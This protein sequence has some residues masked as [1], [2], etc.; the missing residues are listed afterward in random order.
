M[1][2]DVKALMAEFVG[3]FALVFIGALSVAVAGQVFAEGAGVLGVLIAA[4]AHGL[5][6]LGFAFA[7]G[8]LSG[9]HFN[10]AVTAG[11]LAGGKVDIARAISYWVVQFIAAIVAAF[12]M[13]AV[14]PAEWGISRFGQT[15]GVITSS[16]LV[17]AVL[18][19]AILTFL[20]VTVI[21]QTAAHGKAGQFAPIA[22]G[23]T[24]TFCILGGGVF[25]GASLNPAR[26]LGPAL[27]AGDLSYVPGY[28]IGIFAGGVLAG[29]FNAYVLTPKN[30]DE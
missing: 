14:V 7:V 11:L 29:V 22:I 27:A 15:V 2:L 19:E 21:F 16:N 24:L 9:G 12:A 25:S 17:G 18:L 28:L 20:F 23:L 26:T 8:H 3:T 10:P 5:V 4:F 6:V 1:K 13:T 30:D